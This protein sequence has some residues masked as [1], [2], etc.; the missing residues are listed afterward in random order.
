MNRVECTNPDLLEIYNKQVSIASKENDM[1]LCWEIL[2]DIVDAGLKPDVFSYTC[3]INA[4]VRSNHMLH[5]LKTFQE[6]KSSGVQP[7]TVTFNCLINLY[8]N[9]ND[10]EGVESILNEMQRDAVMKDKITLSSL[11]KYFVNN[12]DLEGAKGALEEMKQL[13]C[14][15]MPRLLIV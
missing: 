3:I 1:G 11:I 10:I 12:G 8:V 6:M 13:G 9:N 4:Q 15:R 2:G 14:S 7:N 5:A